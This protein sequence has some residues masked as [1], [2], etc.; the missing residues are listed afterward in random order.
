MNMIC[1]TRGP[2]KVS[3]EDAVAAWNTRPAQASEA[4][5]NA[6]LEVLSFRDGDLPT[7]GWLKDCDAS[8]Q[9]LFKLASALST[10]PAEPVPGMN[11]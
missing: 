2:V 3:T 1:S 5:R 10:T 9:S 7:R 4:I 6:A 8:R 11:R